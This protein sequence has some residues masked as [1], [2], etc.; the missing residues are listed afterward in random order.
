MPYIIPK[1]NCSDTFIDICIHACMHACM[2]I[3]A[4]L[5]ATARKHLGA[6]ERSSGGAESGA[7]ERKYTLQYIHWILSY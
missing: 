3:S 5:A 4:G 7:S 1:L 6:K 2:C